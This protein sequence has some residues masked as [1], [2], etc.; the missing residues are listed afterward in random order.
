MNASRL[1]LIA[2]GTLLPILTARADLNSGLV[3]Y[4]NFEA[5]GT[6]GIANQVDAGSTHNGTYGSGTTYGIT[7]PAGTGAGFPGDDDY[8]GAEPTETTDRSTMLVGKALNVEKNDASAI[9]GTGWFNVPTLSAATLGSNFTV[10]AWFYLAPDADNTGGVTDIL[11]DYVFEAADNN[12]FDVSFGTSDADGNTFVSWVGSTSGAQNAGTLSTGTW[13]HVVHVFA[14]S[15]PNTTMS[16]FIDGVKTGNTVSSATTNMNF[17]S[18]NFGAARTGYR[19]FDGMLDEV[20]VWNRS[21]ATA[22][23]AE[24][25]QRG[26]ASVGLT[27]DLAAL[28]K[29]FVNVETSDSVMG[30]A[31]GTGVYNLN[32]EILIEAEPASGYV[33][34]DWVTPF[35]GQAATFDHTVTGP[36]TITAGFEQDTR[37]PDGDGLTNYEELVTYK[38]SGISADDAD[39]DD[40]LI[41][42]RVE[43]LITQTNP[44]ASQLAAVNY[45]IANLG[46]GAGPNDTVLTRNQANNTLTMTVKAKASNTLVGWDA[47]TSASGTTAGQSGGSLLL[48]TPGT[49]DTKRFFQVEGTEP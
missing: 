15:G 5:E 30:R 27:A 46:G 38:S 29:A 2:L 36:A 24:L 48:Q 10:A 45:I 9:S 31:F 33:F 41:N 19:I 18:L 13:H 42:D 11:R 8:P 39:S 40:D 17:T 37:D 16:V 34:S 20:A 6:D 1:S 43:L 7:P 25:Y 3:A 26:K 21:I 44:T 32:S 12:N 14:Q 49:A 28:G 47:L 4:Y 35:S 23:V 22:E